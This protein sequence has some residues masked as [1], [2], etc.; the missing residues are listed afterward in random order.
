MSGS[1]RIRRAIVAA[2]F[3]LVAILSALRSGAPVAIAILALSVAGGAAAMW[4]VLRT[5]AF[6]KRANRTPAA[7]ILAGLG[8]ILGLFASSALAAVG[9]PAAAM[10][11]LSALCGALAGAFGVLQLGR[12]GSV[13]IGPD[14]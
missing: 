9:G 1:L 12:Y 6:R 11:G 3:A 14:T 10:L 7:S 8:A 4:F 13:W 2:A 5:G